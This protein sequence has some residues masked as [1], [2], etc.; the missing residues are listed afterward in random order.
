MKP[1]HS[2]FAACICSMVLAWLGGCT[3]PPP[4]A[5]AEDQRVLFVTRVKPVLQYYCIECHTIES[6]GKYGGL[7]LEN[8]EL[9]MRTGRHAPVIH[10]GKPDESLLFIVLRLGHEHV[11][12]MPPAP[13]KISDEQL[14][15]IRTWIR[16][17]AQWPA[18]KDG[19]LVLPKD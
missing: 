5:S 6:G 10:P 17:G 18:G 7:I 8:G 14:D 4:P 12:G 13:D 2:F 16:D 11:L 1:I 19:H 3:S 9:A 15:A